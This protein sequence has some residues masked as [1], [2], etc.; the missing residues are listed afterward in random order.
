ML[1][2]IFSMRSI[3][4]VSFASTRLI[5]LRLRIFRTVE[6]LTPFEALVRTKRSVSF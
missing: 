4:S 3:P 2:F 6:T 5:P 1:G